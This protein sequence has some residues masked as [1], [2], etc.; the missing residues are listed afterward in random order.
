MDH[1]SSAEK[2][3]FIHALCAA[4]PDIVFFKDAAGAYLFANHSFERLY[5]YTLAQIHGKTDFAFLSH[6]E[7]TYFEARDKEALA[8]GRATV[9]E[10]WQLNEMTDAQE[11]FQTTKTPVYAADGQLIGLLGVVRNVTEQRLAQDLLRAAAAKP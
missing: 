3:A 1:L 10:A 6:E 2:S 5:G 9:S 8:A 4:I 11:C 7:A